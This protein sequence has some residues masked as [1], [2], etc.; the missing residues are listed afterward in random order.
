MGLLS[1]SGFD[2]LPLLAAVLSFP[3]TALGGGGNQCP[4]RPPGPLG[5][6]EQ[7]RVAHDPK[8]PPAHSDWSPWTHEPVCVGPKA[9]GKGAALCAFVKDD[10]RGEAGLLVVTSPEI[11]AADHSI[12]EDSD[13]RRVGGGYDRRAAA[14]RFDTPSPFEVREVPGK[15]LGAVANATIRA[16]D[17][18]LR[19]RPVLLQLTE[20]ADPVG[21][22]QALWVLEEG[23]VRLPLEDQRRVF[24]LSR[25]TGGH[26]LEDVI[27]TNTFGATL[28][29]VGHFGLFPRAARINH[30]CM[31]NAITRFSP[32][33]LELE[34]VAYKDVQPGEELTISY[35]MLNMLYEER[36]QALREWGFD[37]ACALCSSPAAVAASDGRRAR[38][39]AVLAALEDPALSGAASTVTKLAG[40]LE[41]VAAREGLEAQTGEFYGMVARAYAR[42][43]EVGAAG[44]YAA[45]AAERLERFVGYDD[46]RT[47]KARGLLEELGKVGGGGGGGGGA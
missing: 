39:Q 7:C 6:P 22:M 21:R 5:T 16:G 40:E 26:V 2:I 36:K 17:V 25:S 12:I 23:F 38:L 24:D 14:A 11:A 37:C 47:A 42:A 18:L 13:P 35:S 41:R 31:P 4:W 28:N 45:M 46:D 44:R 1:F 43:G 32:R 15:G 3:T 9:A 27:R 19:E 33:T 8:T 20:L 29:D 30:A 10:F 34:V